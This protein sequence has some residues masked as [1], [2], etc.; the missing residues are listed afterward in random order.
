[1]FT[2]NS[3]K[4]ELQCYVQSFSSR[5]FS[6][7]APRS[8]TAAVVVAMVVAADGMVAVVAGTVVMEAGTVVMAVIGAMAAA[9]ANMRVAGMARDGAGHP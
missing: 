6:H 3:P 1:L 5:Q 9:V 2:D 4:G 8:L 7:P